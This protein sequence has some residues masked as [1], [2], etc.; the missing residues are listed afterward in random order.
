M[1]AA[2]DA[3]N[4]NSQTSFIKQFFKNGAVPS[5]II[6]SKNVLDDTEVKRIQTRIAEQYTGEQNW[7][8]IMVLDADAEFQKTG[9]NLDE[10]VFPDLRAISETRICA[11]SRCRR[12]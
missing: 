11:A 5:G 9:L 12:S 4:D 7:H 8:K 6:K 2:F 10:M 3:D 1:A